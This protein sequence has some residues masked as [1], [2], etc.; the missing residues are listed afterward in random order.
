MFGIGFQEILIGMFFLLPIYFLPT[1]VARRKEH[2]QTIGIFLVNL[3]FGLTL[4]G[5]VGAL[6]WA[7][8]GLPAGGRQCPFCMGRVET[9]A[10]K[11]RHCGEW[12]PVEAEA[13]RVSIAE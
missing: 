10:Q 8:V 5:W 3:F 1:L 9:A 13:Q 6:V 12:L 11:C 7:T 2:P 4:L